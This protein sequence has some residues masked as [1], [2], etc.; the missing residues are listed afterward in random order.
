MTNYGFYS[1]TPLWTVY[2]ILQNGHELDFIGKKRKYLS[3]FTLKTMP[4]D[5][6]KR[7]NRL[8]VVKQGLHIL[9]KS[10]I[11]PSEFFDFFLSDHYK[12]GQLF[13]MSLLI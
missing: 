2:V 12:P 9:E 6:R 13:T 11:Q 5:F 1:E 4:T 3:T 7:K 8:R 10:Q